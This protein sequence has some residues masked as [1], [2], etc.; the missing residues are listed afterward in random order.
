MSVLPFLK[1]IILRYVRDPVLSTSV[2][3]N[4]DR[5]HPKA[6]VLPPHVPVNVRRL[7]AAALTIRAL[8]TR[9]LSALVLEVP[10][11]TGLLA[12]CAGTVG[13]RKPLVLDERLPVRI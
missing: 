10:R 9:L 13:T 11:Q 2:L 6:H 5:E 1:P 4:V 7:F 3:V 8:K 12:E